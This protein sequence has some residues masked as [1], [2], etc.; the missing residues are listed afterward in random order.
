MDVEKKIL[1]DSIYYTKQLSIPFENNTLCIKGSFGHFLPL[2]IISD[3]PIDNLEMLVGGQSIIK[4][5]LNFSTKLVDHLCNIQKSSKNAIEDEQKSFTYKLPWKYFNIKPISSFNLYFHNFRFNVDIKEPCNVRLCVCQY[6]IPYME[7]LNMRKENYNVEN[8]II[9]IQNQNIIINSKNEKQPLY[10][11][12]KIK[13]LF[14]DN[15]NIAKI[16]SF[17]FYIDNVEKLS[18]DSSMMLMCTKKISNNCYYISLDGKR[19][20]DNNWLSAC[21][22]NTKIMDFKINSIIE[23]NI[24]IRVINHNTIIYKHLLAELGNY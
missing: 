7:R 17:I 4:F 21:N 14:L 15:I 20:N 10:I 9:Q 19:F 22:A 1:C 11:D 24:V 8:D 16:T 18:Y 2:F 5:P 23:Q 12:G 13:G 6:Y 3:K